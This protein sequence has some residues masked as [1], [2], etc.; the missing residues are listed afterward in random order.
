MRR[1]ARSGG[2]T[3][4]EV[5]VALSLLV[6]ALA[7]VFGM[8]RS[9]GRATERADAVAQRSERMRAVQGLLRSQ[10]SG[11]MPV[12]MRIDT[13]S[14]EAV[15]MVGDERSV[16]FVGNM[17]G[18]L[19]R[20]GPYWQRFELVRG[21]DGMQLRFEFRQMTPDGPLDPERPPQ[22]L[23]DGIRDAGFQYRSLDDQM[24]PG[25]WTRDWTYR[26][27]LPPLVRLN[28]RF[29][30]ERRVWPDFVSHLPLGASYGYGPAP[31]AGDNFV[32]RQ[33]DATQ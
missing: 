2:F 16:E 20:G 29:N 8:V 13:E 25:P 33:G 12:P 19:S 4:I 10:L 14:G 7:L 1:V 28:L 23:L 6:A 22:V 3:L 30:D 26:A 21:G 15:F 11:A 17:P 27:M 9:T 18:Y 24:K 5:I 31:Q 32:P